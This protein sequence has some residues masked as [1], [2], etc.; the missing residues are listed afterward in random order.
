MTEIEVVSESRHA[1]PSPRAA[2]SARAG[3]RDR[4]SP[5]LAQAMVPG[6]GLEGFAALG[7]VFESVGQAGDRPK[8]GRVSASATLR[9][10]TA[11][12]AQYGQMVRRVAAQLIAKLPANVE[13]D[14]L[15]QAGMI[16]LFDALAR[17]QSDQGAKFETFAMQR[18]RGA[19]LDEL[20]EADWLPRSVRRNQR[21]IDAAIRKVEQRKKGSATEAEVAAEMGMPIKAYQQLL[22]ETCGSQLICLDDLGDEDSDDCFLE[23]H[24]ITEE[25]ESLKMLRDDGFRKALVDSIEDLPEREK[26][27][28]GMYYEHEMNLREIAAVLGVTESRVSQLRSQAVGRLRTKM[29][30]WA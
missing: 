13:L 4:H 16:G 27:V 8:D 30:N 12:V 20:R 28:M 19:M 7:P 22:A 26:A 18:V 25:V 15:V 2:R 10:R 3:G 14:D 9:E 29:R 17:Y 1:V 24:L 11:A 23:R 5:D 21:S 6:V